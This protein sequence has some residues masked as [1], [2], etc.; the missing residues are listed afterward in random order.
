MKYKIRLTPLDWYFF[1]GEATFGEGEGRR[2]FA[3]SNLLP[4]ET[5]IIGM[6]RFELLKANGLIPI[7]SENKDGAIKKIGINGFNHTDSNLSIG[8]IKSIS[9]LFIEYQ[10]CELLYKTPNNYDKELEF[11]KEGSV[12]L[13]NYDYTLDGSE[14]KKF[15][16]IPFIKDF[17]AKN[18]KPETWLSLKN[19]TE[20]TE[21]NEESQTSGIFKKKIKIGITKQQEDRFDNNQ[22]GYFKT[23][24]CSLNSDYSFVVFADI[25]DDKIESDR[26]VYLGAERSMFKMEAEKIEKHEDVDYEKVEEEI[27]GN[28]RKNDSDTI[29][30]FFISDAFVSSDILHL[31]K[32]AW[33]DTNP[34][35]NIVRSVS[36]NK[37]YSSLSRNEKS[38]RLNLIKRGSV[39]FFEASNEETVLKQIDNQYLQNWGYNKYIK[40][41]Q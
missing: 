7:T 31:C 24:F 4:Q 3:K 23:E 28:H 8:A 25:E 39:L 15:K 20:V 10:K 6:L 1:G 5:A 17:S 37:N 38:S 32:F 29:E 18:Y 30:L 26:L 35:R 22:D 11:K 19:R 9:P 40:V 13:E 2:Y 36:E 12:S 34:F 21:Y 27:K 16:P 41:N 33:F 14:D